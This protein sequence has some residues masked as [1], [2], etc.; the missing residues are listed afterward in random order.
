MGI[1][2]S[3]SPCECRYALSRLIF[4]AES[5]FGHDVVCY[6]D[7]FFLKL[8]EFFVFTI[9]RFF[10]FAFVFFI[11]MNEISHRSLEIPPPPTPPSI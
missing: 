4:V 9:S 7:A 2:L 3:R 5:V 8:I 1:R 6:I 11:T 10:I